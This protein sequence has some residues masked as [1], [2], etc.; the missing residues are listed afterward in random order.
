MSQTA[1]ALSSEAGQTLLFGKCMTTQQVSVAWWNFAS[2]GAVCYSVGAA[3]HIRMTFC[4]GGGR[5]FA[6]ANSFVCLAL[7]LDG[8]G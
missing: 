3:Q 6:N 1:P 8:G 7:S 5:F 4:C 2:N